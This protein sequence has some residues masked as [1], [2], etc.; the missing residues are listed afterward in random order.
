MDRT[1]EYFQRP[2]NIWLLSRL[3]LL[4]ISLLGSA[5]FV[6]AVHD[7]RAFSFWGV[8]VCFLGLLIGMIR[9]PITGYSL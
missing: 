8:I 6:V 1:K 4:P 2:D 7:V 3:T 5:I 9:V